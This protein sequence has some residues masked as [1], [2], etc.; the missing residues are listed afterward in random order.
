MHLI[1][2]SV[3]S[4]AAF[5]LAHVNQKNVFHG[6]LCVQGCSAFALHV[7]FHYWTHFYRAELGAG[8]SRCDRYRL[9]QVFRLDQVVAAE[10]F[11]GLSERAV[12]DRGLAVAHPNRS[13]GRRLLEWVP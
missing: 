4:P 1:L 3:A 8:D 7:D 12:G 10:L 5:C 13:R 9:V 6:S 11:L 2:L